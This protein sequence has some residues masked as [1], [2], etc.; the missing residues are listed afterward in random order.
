[1]RL[2][3]KRK[4]ATILLACSLKMRNLN[5]FRGRVLVIVFVLVLPT[6]YARAQAPITAVLPEADDYFRLT[7]SAR[8]VFEAKG[9]MENG[10]LSHAQIG[11]SLQFNVRPFKKLKEITLF[12]LDDMKSMPI[13]FTIGYRYLPSTAQPNINRMQPILMFHI[14]FPGTTL[15]SDRNR[16]DLDWSKGNFNW[17]YRNRITAE[18]RLAIRSYH[19]G[20]YV[21]AEFSYQSQFSKWS[22]TRLFAGCLLPLSKRFELD[23]YYEHVNSTGVH[24]NH[25]VNAAGLALNLYL[26]RRRSKA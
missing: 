25:Q 10:D 1:M 24:P 26:S 5:H 16:A 2:H 17:T 4:T 21:S 19:P 22:V 15:V 23:G 7:S 20:P 6:V 11:P 12:D 13:V 14:P 8:L 9:Y 18:R 3:S